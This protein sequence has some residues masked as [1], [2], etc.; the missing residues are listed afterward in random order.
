MK[1]CI[2]CKVEKDE[3]EFSPNKSAGR[4]L[5]SWCKECMAEAH[6]Q[7]YSTDSEYRAWQHEYN[8]RRYADPVFRERAVARS[9]ARY[10]DPEHRARAL[11]YQ[12]EYNKEYQKQR[13]ANDAEFRR[14]HLQRSDARQ[15]SL[16]G[17]YTYEEWAAKLEEFNWHCALCGCDLL[18]LPAR[19]VT[20]DH[21][22]PVSKGGLNVISNIQPAC[23]TCNSSKGNRR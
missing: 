3:S 20:A 19:D 12:R 1:R 4:L 5:H 10:A 16:V 8:M 6:R 14:Y 18:Q 7:R 11:E 2:K 15:R 22:V 9:A 21:I 13:L 23:R 17:S